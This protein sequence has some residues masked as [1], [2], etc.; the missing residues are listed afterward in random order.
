[1]RANGLA[2]ATVFALAL[3]WAAPPARAQ[4]PTV[5]AFE[6]ARIIIGDGS[7][8]IDNGTLIVDGTRITQVGPSADV[9]APAGAA[10]VNLAGKTVMPAIVDTHTHLSHTRDAL[11]LDLKRRAYYGIGAVQ[12]L[13]QDSFDLLYMR[14]EMI[15]G[16]ARYFSAGRGIT[17]PEPGCSMAPFWINNEAEGRKAVQELAAAKVD[18]VKIYVDSW[19]DR[20]PR[21]PPDI[22]ATLIDEAHRDGLRVTA[23]LRDIEDAKRLLRAGIDAFA[24]GVRTSDIDDEA[25]ALYKQ[26]ANLVLVPT[27]P[28]RGVK[29]DLS[30]LRDSMPADQLAKL[31]AANTDR[32][33]RQKEFGIQSR[34]LAKLNAA[35][36]RIAFGTDGN[37]PWAPH[38][39]MLDMVMSGMT[40]MQVITAAT[41]NSAE[42]MRI[43]DMGTLAPD[44]SADFIV[45][46]ANPLDDITN[47]RRIA[48][49]YLRGA[50]V[51][52]SPGQGGGMPDGSALCQ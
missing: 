24:H 37:T 26:R 10:H 40:P 12:S 42:F 9:H 19:G 28:N 35:G 34:N 41:R 14:N 15:P 27:L 1:M 31:E 50:A 36:I 8:P 30:W 47:T 3:A 43:A 22:Y 29:A 51:D 4:A 6:G 49:V 33:Q 32:P 17:T 21:M 18:I 13:G 39:Q 20:F 2:A 52:R 38:V 5:R 16:A 44:K 48:A 23:H 45:L 25:V 7:A 46:N 11:I